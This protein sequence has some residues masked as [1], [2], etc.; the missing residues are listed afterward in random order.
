VRERSQASEREKRS[1]GGRE[2]RLLFLLLSLARALLSLERNNGDATLLFPFLTFF[3]LARA[4]LSLDNNATLLALL[5]LER[6]R[7]RARVE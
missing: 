3:S 6:A 4:S 5:V 1:K 2:F 7:E